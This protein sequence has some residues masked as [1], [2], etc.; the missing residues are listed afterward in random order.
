MR[1]IASKQKS[2]LVAALALAPLS[3]CE[4]MVDVNVKLIEPC[5]QRGQALAGVETFQVS[6]DGPGD[7]NAI[8]ITKAGSKEALVMNALAEDVTVTVQGYVGDVNRDGAVTS[9]EPRAIGRSLPLDIEGQAPDMDLL[10]TMGQVD[11]FGQTTNADGTCTTTDNGTNSVK[12][13]HGHT[14]TYLPTVNKVLIVGGAVWVDD[15]QSGDRG[16]AFV[17]VPCP[18]RPDRSCGTAE[19][20]DPATGTFEQLPPMPSVRAYH[21]ATALPD[22]RVLIAGGFG[23]FSGEIDARTD[24]L[25]FEPG[26]SNPWSATHSDGRR[27]LNILDQRAMHTATLLPQKQL[28]LLIG[29]CNGEG[30]RPREVRNVGGD[31]T[32]PP[33]L[34]NGIVVYDIAADEFIAQP[35]VLA[36]PRAMHAASEAGGRVIISGGVNPNTNGPVCTIEVFQASGN[37]VR[38]LNP[39]GVEMTLSL[40]PVGHT[41][42]TLNAGRV[43]LIGGQTEAQGGVPSG[44]GSNVV[45]FWNT[46]IGVETLQATMLSGRYNHASALLSDSSILV[47]GGS[48]P[49][50]GATAER[51]VP[52]GETFMQKALLEPMQTARAAL[53]TAKLPNNQV[54]V[55]GGYVDGTP[56]ISSDLVEIYF[57]R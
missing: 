22:G 41:Q 33:L 47:M 51:L 14:V 36:T 25:I 2:L 40:C 6:H 31:P 43:A 7:N 38:A 1:R 4:P 3:A 26:A 5:N 13:R 48:V 32:A 27:S 29:G 52:Q 11:S 15:A 10:I 46:T 30:C 9:G 57:G 42:V 49:L 24:A 53:G 21:T 55:V 16:E 23:V 50:G 54:L 19:L 12:G 37:T 17:S 39:Q 35:G 56:R 44:P 45:Q 18:D 28:V 34:N 8:L 20:F